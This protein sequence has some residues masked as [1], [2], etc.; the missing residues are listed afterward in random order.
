MRKTFM[1]VTAAIA[2]V[3]GSTA[4]FAQHSGSYTGPRGN[5]TSW[6]SSASNGTASGTITG[7]R[8][9]T[10]SGTATEHY[11]GHGGY[12][13]SGSVTGPRGVTRS[14]STVVYPY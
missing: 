7:P 3:A 5:T 4:A 2:F 12:A 10:V 9:N 8:G 11:V 1:A 6:S 14:G 13:V